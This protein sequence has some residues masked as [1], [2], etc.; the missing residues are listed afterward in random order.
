MRTASPRAMNGPSL[1]TSN[2]LPSIS[3]NPAGRRSLA[4]TVV[5]PTSARSSARKAGS[6][7][8]RTS[9]SLGGTRTAL[10]SPGILGS[11]FQNTPRR[12]R[13]RED[14]VDDVQQVVAQDHALG[15]VVGQHE[16]LL[17]QDQA[18]DQHRDAEGREHDHA[19]H[20]EDLDRDQADA[21][22]EQQDLGPGREAHV[23]ARVHREPEQHQAEGAGDREPRR[24]ELDDQ[25]QEAEHEQDRLHA[26]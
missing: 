15:F 3:M 4:A 2:L 9:A 18:D 23:P 12:R 25:H 22:E 16:R 11:S 1:E 13:D 24:L 6:G 21:R 14:Q 5:R 7:G 19:R 10:R 8:P 17:A 20:Q 26:H